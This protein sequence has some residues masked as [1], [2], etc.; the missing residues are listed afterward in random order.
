[1]SQEAALLKNTEVLSPG[2]TTIT[3]SLPYLLKKEKYDDAS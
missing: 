3:S 2:Y 1:M